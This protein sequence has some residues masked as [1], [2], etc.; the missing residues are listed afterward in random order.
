MENKLFRIL[1]ILSI[2]SMSAFSTFAQPKTVSVQGVVKDENG[3]PLPGVAVMVVGASQ[4]TLTGIDG[5][6]SID[7]QEGATLDFQSLGYTSQQ[8]KVSASAPKIDVTMR[9]SEEFIEDA[10]VIAYGTAKKTDLTGSVT[11]IKVDDIKDTP[12][13]SVDNALQGRIAGADIMS[14]SGE[15]GA[16][17]SIRIRGTRSITASNEPLIIVDGVMDAISNLND[18]NPA[19]IQSLSVL[20]DAS[21]T[22]LYGSR[23]ANGVII[24][25]TKQG[26]TSKPSITF[27]ADAG[28]ARLAT[29]LDLMNSREFA[30][31]WNDYAYFAPQYSI[32][33]NTPLSKYPYPDPYSLDDGTNWIKE[34]T[35]T[36]PYQNYNLSATGGSKTSSYY[37]SFGYNDTQGIIKDNGVKRYTGRLNLDYQ[38][39]KWLKVGYKGSYTYRMEDCNKAAIGGKNQYSAAMYLSPLI[40]PDSGYNPFYA[41]GTTINTPVA[42][43]KHNTYEIDRISS[44]HTAYAEVQFRKNLKLKS[45]VTYYTYQRHTYRYYPSTLPKKVDGEGGEAYRAEYD[46]TS[47]LN[48]NTLTYKYSKKGHTIDALAGF[49][50][51]T[52][53]DN[54]FGLSG[55]GYQDDKVMWN[56]MNAVLDKQT[57]SASTSSTKKAKMSFLARLNYNYK[58]RYYLTVTG[59]ADGS[60]NFA[61]NNKWGFFPSAAFRWNIANEQFLK[62]V[63][64]IDNLSL[65]LSAGRTG[66]DAISAYRSLAAMSSTTGGYLF[67]GSQPVAYYQGRLASDNLTW[68]KTD[69]YN[70]ALD[71]ELF[72]GRLSATA[73][74]YLSYTSD[75]LLSVQTASASGYSTRYANAGRTSNKGIEFSLESRNIVKRDF[76]WVTNITVA[77]NTQKVI[78]IGSEDYVAV[79]SSPGNNPYMMYGYVAGYPLNSLWGFRYGG[80]WKNVDEFKRNE[81]TKAYASGSA[82]SSGNYANS[83]G[84]PRFYDMNHDGSLSEEDLVYLGNADPYIYG[85]INN[86]FIIGKFNIGIYFAYSLGG[87]IYN[88]SELYMSGSYQTNQYKYMLN[89]WHPTRNPDSDV[90][91]AGA[92][93]VDLPSDRIVHDASYLRLKTVSIGYTFEM[94]KKVNF[95]RD[96]KVTL[97]GDNLFLLKR[98]NGFDPDVSTEADGSTLRRVDLGAY[99]KARTIVFS[100]QLR[101]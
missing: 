81:V 11:S 34:I 16:S 80:T 50:A 20:K 90:P 62:G 30:R 43:I 35:R 93:D 45:T 6:Y 42:T 100:V 19:D 96:I 24:I 31:Y 78:D 52:Y 87:K 98:Y 84:L 40:E 83:L 10:V 73:E 5:D 59:R 36:A 1:T 8:F 2:F 55:S 23:A 71:V 15:P 14:T 70:L 68:E 13:M 25:T 63:K 12:T 75:L 61:A 89:A 38:M 33:D 99:P 4:G 54:N 92:F 95:L 7:V 65:R 77:H 53:N 85:G 17:T 28:F 37:A 9:T 44:S 82:I 29:N 58:S 47:V 76:S 49:T 79:S 69:L 18:I 66:N 21:S 56:N 88:Y 67:G 91:R 41:N 32:D 27:K 94:P 26:K 46:Q 97:S 64:W 51:Y 22:A 86:S 3:E 48:E 39:F 72:Q 60:S 57:Y 74:A 101:Y